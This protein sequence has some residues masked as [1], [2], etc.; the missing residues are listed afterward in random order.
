MSK[1]SMIGAGSAVFARRLMTDVLS[2]P[3]FEATEICL[4]DV[5][6]ERLELIATLLRKMVAERKLGARIEATTDRQRALDGADY[7]ITTIAVGWNYERERPEVAIPSRYGLQ[8]SVADTIGVGGIFRFLRTAPTMLDIC[9]DIERLCPTALLLNYVNPMA[10]LCW[11]IGQ[12][13]RART[14]GLCHS[15]QGTAR[16][17]ATYADVPFD[18]ISYWTAGINHQA[19]Y[20]TLRRGQENL[21][22]RLRE[23]SADPKILEQDRVRFEILRHFGYFVTESSRHMSEY[24][25]YFRRTPELIEQFSPPPPQSTAARREERFASI[26]RQIDGAEPIDYNRT[27]EYCSYIIHALETNRLFRFNANVPNHDLIS[28]LPRGCCVE[29][30]CLADGSGIHPCHVGDLP[31]Q[32]AAVNRT[33]VNV[34]ELAVRALLEADREAI[35]QAVQV[36]PLASSV[37][38][39]AQMRQMTDEVL[40]E[41]REWVRF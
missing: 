11:A 30:P 15:V 3:E 17:L 19:W 6:T 5:N 27:E 1:I 16:Q 2:W 26:R 37:L 10:M 14:I 31:A 36:D 4:M 24:V 39:L 25:P 7:V 33:N 23:R 35:Y 38:S 21:Y 18:E 28:N 12:A 34:Q 8:Q 20:L 13:T 41:H 9:H 32:L 29:V 40:K 22:P